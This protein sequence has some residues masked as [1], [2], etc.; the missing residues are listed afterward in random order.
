MA[1]TCHW[2][3]SADTLDL[4]SVSSRGFEAPL[5]STM[6]I[7]LSW[8]CISLRPSGITW[9]LRL[10]Y[11]RG[12]CVR[13]HLTI[14]ATL[15]GLFL[16]HAGNHRPFSLP[17]E[18]LPSD[19][20]YILLHKEKSFLLLLM[21]TYALLQVD[22]CKHQIPTIFKKSIYSNKKSVYI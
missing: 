17:A 21:V 4:V 11:F 12:L 1:S 20:L 8:D 3:T 7:L 5:L 6:S 18:L 19:F 10:L 9:R 16:Y 15:C 22:E 14:L 2:M 13:C